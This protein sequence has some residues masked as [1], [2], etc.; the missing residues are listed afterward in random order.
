MEVFLK[1]RRVM[2]MGGAGKINARVK[3]ES[4]GYLLD[5]VFRPS[6]CSY[7][8]CCGQ[9]TYSISKKFKLKEKAQEVLSKACIGERELEAMDKFS[10]DILTYLIG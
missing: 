7:S 1:I 2:G 4:H 9:D 3:P 5:H 8:V 10:A 6:S